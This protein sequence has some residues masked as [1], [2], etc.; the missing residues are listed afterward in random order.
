MS[1][2]FNSLI[3]ENWENR[4]FVEVI[5]HGLTQ[6]TTF[7]TDIEKNTQ[8]NLAALNEKLSIIEKNLSLIECR[9][10]SVLNGGDVN[11]NVAPQNLFQE[12]NNRQTNAINDTGTG[13]GAPAAP[14]PPSSNAPPPP[15]PPGAGAPAPPPAPPMGSNAPPPPPPQKPVL[16]G[17]DRPCKFTIRDR[18]N[19]YRGCITED[20]E[21]YNN[22]GTL[23]GFVSE[24]EA[25]NVDNEFF[26]LIRSD[27]V[28]ENALG[29]PIGTL[30]PGRAYLIDKNGSTVAEM[31]GTGEVRGHAGT[32]LGQFEGFD[33][34]DMRTVALYLLLVDPG[35]LSEIEG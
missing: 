4:E 33:Y 32:Y 31:Q 22:A 5:S 26:G 17:P 2:N 21:C 25:G 15:P 10:F 23:I 12:T 3:K 19:D 28:I 35:M 6:L 1:S 29:E 18:M 20:G 24:P 9:T 11:N 34:H 16:T 30:D 27:E 13:A 14:P 8:Y 7:L